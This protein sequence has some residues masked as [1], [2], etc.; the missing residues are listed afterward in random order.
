MQ[1]DL[2]D[3]QRAAQATIRS[4][5]AKEVTPHVPRWER[6]RYFP[7]DLVREMGRQGFF[8]AAF[9]EAVGG[10]DMGFLVH[11]ILCEEVSRAWSSLRSLFN[12]QA[13]TVAKTVL[14][15]GTD[16]QREYVPRWLSGEL[17]GCFAL[18][19][20]NHGSDVAG[21]EATARDDGD[22]WVLNG[23]KTW[24]T[25]ATVFDA[26]VVFV[27]TDPA[28]RHGGISAFLL[29]PDVPGLVREEIADKL[30]HH[31]SPTGTLTF[32]DCRLPKDRLIGEVGQGF[33]IAMTALE[34]GRLSVA[35]GGLGVAQAC[36]DASVR[37]ANE[38]IQFGR[39]IAEYQMVQHKIADMAAAVEGARLLVYRSG[40]L[41]DQGTRDNYEV[42]LAKY[43][44]AEAAVKA[45]NDTLEIYGGNGYSEEFPAARLYRDAKMYQIGEGAANI[46]RLVI[47]KHVLGLKRA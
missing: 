38:R 36:L 20:P 45:A 46:T 16:A 12:M 42:T 13:M 47:A 26:G 17:L 37:Y 27:K 2:T 25:H 30:G 15:F 7:R 39:P 10:T 43:V 40:Y 24:I 21:M 33:R 18:T 1:F 11:A 6:E 14:D 23:S 29:T 9:P 8:A 19:E 41:K 32:S 35:A 5:C 4:F 31:G 3:E 34:Y 22:A 28:Q 44:A